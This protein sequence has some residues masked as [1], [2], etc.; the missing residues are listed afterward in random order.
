MKHEFS[1]LKYENSVFVVCT[2]VENSRQ[3]PLLRVSFLVASYSR[4]QV[5]ESAAMPILQLLKTSAFDPEAANTLASAFS[6]AWDVLR[7]SGSTLAANDKAV[8]TRHVLANQIITLG[9]AGERD[10]QR[11]VKEALVYVASCELIARGTGRLRAN[12]RVSRSNKTA[13]Q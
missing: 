2:I 5:P 9:R 1:R 3:R 6:T 7:R 10:Q 12:V 8:M 13:A 11:L 4:T